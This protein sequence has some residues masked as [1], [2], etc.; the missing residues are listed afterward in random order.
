[1][2]LFAST[3]SSITTLLLSSSGGYHHDEIENFVSISSP[4]WVQGYVL[5]GASVAKAGCMGDSIRDRVHIYD[6]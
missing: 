3:W 2:Q 6:A 1:V 4:V 5:V